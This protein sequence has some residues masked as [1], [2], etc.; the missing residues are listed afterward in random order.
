VVL[1]AT[2]ALLYLRDSGRRK[3]GLGVVHGVIGAA[4]LCLLVLA[5]RGPRR[6]D[7]MGVGSFGLAASVLFGVALAIGPAIPLLWRRSPRGAGVAVA[8]HA[9]FAIT[10]FVLFLAWTSFP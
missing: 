5:L 8:I 1:G 7:A 4:G 10:A 9:G 6:G 3:T 2:L